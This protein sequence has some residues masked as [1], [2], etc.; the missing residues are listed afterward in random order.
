MAMGWRGGSRPVVVVRA[1]VRVR[2]V[3]AWARVVRSGAE[4]CGVVR[5]ARVV[6]VGG[7]VACLYLKLTLAQL[8]PHPHPPPYPH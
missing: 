5:I 3:V 2:V 8:N 6:I 7:G 4:W 1:R